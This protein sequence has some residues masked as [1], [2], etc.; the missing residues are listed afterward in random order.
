MTLRKVAH[1]AHVVMLSLYAELERVESRCDPR[2]A[3]WLL[4]TRSQVEA[5]RRHADFLATALR[6]KAYLPL[7]PQDLSPEVLSPGPDYKTAKKM[8]DAL[9]AT[10]NRRRQ[11]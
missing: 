11:G 3:D 7:V 2:D 4:A 9:G 1:R 6:S 8:W 5:Q 10:S